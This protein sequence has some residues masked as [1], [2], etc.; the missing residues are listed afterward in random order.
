MHIWRVPSSFGAK[1]MGNPHGL[2]EVLIS[3]SLKSVSSCHF[4]SSNL[5]IDRGYIIM[6]LSST[7][8]VLMP[9]CTPWSDERLGGSSIQ[10]MPKYCCRR[11]HI[12]RSGWCWWVWPDCEADSSSSLSC[13]TAR[14]A[15]LPQWTWW[16]TCLAEIRFNGSVPCSTDHLISTGWIWC[17][18]CVLVMV[19]SRDC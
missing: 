18:P 9:W 11:S 8:L 3:P 1:T 13:T 19:I 14:M 10:K 16:P 7:S 12:F 15:S 17:L 4:N 2:E 6:F 5:M